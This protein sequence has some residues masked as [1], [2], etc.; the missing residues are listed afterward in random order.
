MASQ[1]RGSNL[2]HLDAKLWDVDFQIAPLAP[3]LL[4]W[5]NFNPHMDK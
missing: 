3:P 1:A 4:T 5:F 2:H